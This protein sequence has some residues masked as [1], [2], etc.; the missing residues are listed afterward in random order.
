MRII[1]LQTDI[2]QLGH[3]LGA[4]LACVTEEV[5]GLTGADGAVLELA[6]GEEMVYRAVS[7]LARAQLGLRLALALGRRRCQPVGI[8]NLDMD[9]LKAIN[10]RHG[11]RAGAAAIREF[12]ARLHRSARESDTVARL[13]GD[14]F[15]VILAEL[16]GRDGA[17]QVAERMAREIREPFAVRDQAVAQGRGVLIPCP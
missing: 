7:G 15:G 14:E 6:E 4:V 13:G 9:G 3:D 12:A 2:V 5:A 8:L 16:E 17:H 1:H 10:D 11:H